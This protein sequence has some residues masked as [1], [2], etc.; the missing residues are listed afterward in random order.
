MKVPAKFSLPVSSAN[1]VKEMLR[2]YG[3]RF[4]DQEHAF[5]HAETGGSH[6]I[7]Y[8]NGTVLLQGRD[9]AGEKWY[10]EL[11][12]GDADETFGPAGAGKQDKVL[13]LDESGKGDYFGPL[14]LAGA[15]VSVKDEK[16]L[17]TAGVEDSKNL[18]DSK[19]KSVFL[20]LKEKTEFQVRVIEPEEYNE[21]Y[22]VHK[23]LN[24]LMMDEYKKLIGKFS[25]KKYD[26]IIL[27]QFSS[28]DKQNQDLKNSLSKEILI[29]TKGESNTSVALASI[30]ARYH[31]IDW[32]AKASG[33]L[34]FEV[35]IGS[36]PLSG[37][38]FRRLKNGGD[39]KLFL[40]VAKAHF[41]SG[42]KAD[43]LFS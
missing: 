30:V 18:Y 16:A 43:L 19:I 26:R 6:V 38:L 10:R 20:K 12:G 39:R 1:A 23:N 21:L 11:T 41:K 31:F 35:P 7:F 32:I 9:P 33:R 17:K 40:S 5:W 3:F 27:D 15:V 22:S 25:L 37:D 42:T 34:G 29:V 36:G 24:R 14:V 28:S 4:A 13:G 2:N 8:R